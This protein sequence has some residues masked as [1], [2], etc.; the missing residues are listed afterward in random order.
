MIGRIYKIDSPKAPNIC[1]IGATTNDLC[2][3]W[4]HHK[5]LYQSWCY[6]YSNPI[7]IF[8]YFKQYGIDSFKITLLKEY[9]IT[10]IKHLHAYEQLW[11]N[12][13]QRTAV[14]K[15]NPVCLITKKMLQN[16]NR[17]LPKV[18][19]GCGSQYQRGREKFHN[20]TKKHNKWLAISQMQES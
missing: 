17:N 20:Q 3:R 7:S 8:P 9:A 4:F 18:K 1:Y 10:D 14:N 16:M 2:I 5:E 13:F 19:C 15:I 11:F 12:R 6:G